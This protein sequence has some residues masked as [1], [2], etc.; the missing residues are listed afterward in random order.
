MNKVSQQKWYLKQQGVG[1]V[2]LIHADTQT[3][4]GSTFNSLPKR[5]WQHRAGRMGEILRASSDVTIKLLEE[6]GRVSK[7]RLRE[8]E[9]AWILDFE[10]SLN[11]QLASKRNSRKHCYKGGVMAR[12]EWFPTKL[13]A[14]ERHGTVPYGTFKSRFSRTKD[15]EYSLGSY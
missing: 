8:R 12:G 7:A 13:R 4:I 11:L 3:Y 14:W 9:S 15:I 1:K 10:P 2:Y 5:L 6:V